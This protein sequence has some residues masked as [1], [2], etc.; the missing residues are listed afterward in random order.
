LRDYQ[1]R[2]G[3]L[4]R[5]RSYVQLDRVT[6]PLKV[7]ARRGLSPHQIKTAAGKFALRPPEIRLAMKSACPVPLF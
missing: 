1:S 2:T 7:H 5:L 3:A 4:E 6:L